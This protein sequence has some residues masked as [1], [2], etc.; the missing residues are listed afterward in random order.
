MKSKDAQFFR[1]YSMNAKQFQI[2]LTELENDGT[3]LEAIDLSE[4]LKPKYLKQLSENLG[5]YIL[6]CSA[7]NVY[8]A[9]GSELLDYVD[10][11]S[12]ARRFISE[13]IAVQ[14]IPRSRCDN[15][16]EWQIHQILPDNSTVFLRDVKF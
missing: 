1:D 12:T 6:F 15:E 8:L 4:Y 2:Y 16:W 13:E 3:N 5:K 11:P 9:K 14:Y 7:R 10:Q